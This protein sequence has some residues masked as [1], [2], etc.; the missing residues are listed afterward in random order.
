VSPVAGD[1]PDSIDT[2][3][4]EAG[5][6]FGTGEQNRIQTFNLEQ[7]RFS[8]DLSEVTAAPTGDDDRVLQH[9][10]SPLAL[11]GVNHD[12]APVEVLA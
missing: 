8:S 7:D 10:G 9:G 4:P 2:A 11:V 1:V 6:I 12:A 5:I 3:D